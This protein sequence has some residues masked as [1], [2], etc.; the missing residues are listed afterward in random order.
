MDSSGIPMPAVLDALVIF[1]A[2]KTPE[3]A[4]LTAALAVIGSLGGNVGL[5]LIARFG[6][7]LV[8]QPLEPGNPRKFRAWFNRYG[9]VTVFIPALLPIPLPL[10]VFVISAGALHTPVPNFLFV[11][12][13]AR[14][15]RYFGEAW[16]GFKLGEDAQSFL[17]RNAW[18]LIGVALALAFLLVA[19]IK[20]NDRRRRGATARPTPE[21]GMGP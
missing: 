8:L 11:I 19:L 3:R 5:F 14:V 15:I 16:L 2:A 6:G 20:L 12:F 21:H 1:V 10:K 4:W 9:L 17:T 13:S 18:N 7:K